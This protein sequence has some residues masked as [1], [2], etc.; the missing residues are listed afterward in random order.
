MDVVGH[1]L[2]AIDGHKD[3]GPSR[4]PERVILGLGERVESHIPGV[5]L[6]AQL[7]AP[8]DFNKTAHQVRLWVLRH[9]TSTLITKLAAFAM[10]AWTAGRIVR[11]FASSQPV[12]S[13]ALIEASS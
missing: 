11:L 12:A 13:A 9:A 10:E 1:T 2:R 8:L 6:A 5:P 7:G 4:L 3:Q